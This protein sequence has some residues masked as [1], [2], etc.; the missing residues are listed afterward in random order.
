[1]SHGQPSSRVKWLVAALLSAS[2]AM[3][4]AQNNVTPDGRLFDANPQLGGSRY[5]FARPASPLLGGNFYA[6]GDVRGGFALRSFSPIPSSN[7][8]RAPLGSSALSGFIRDSVSINEARNPGGLTRAPYYDPSANAPSGLYFQGGAYRAPTPGLRA[9]APPPTNAGALGGTLGGFQPPFETALDLRLNPQT[10]Q[11]AAPGFDVRR[12]AE[13]SSSIFGAPRAPAPLYDGYDPQT[14]PAYAAFAPEKPPT[15][16]DLF[17]QD[18]RLDTENARGQWSP[19]DLRVGA[20]AASDER[21]LS[22]VDLMLKRDSDALLT[23]RANIRFGAGPNAP[24]AAGPPAPAP[25]A[26][27]DAL[28]PPS[29][30]ELGLAPGADVFNDLMLAVSLARDPKADWF[31]QLQADSRDPAL[32]LESAQESIA[33]ESSAFVKRVLDTPIRT[34]VGDDANVLND[35]M[36]KAEAF[37]EIGE[38]FDAAGRYER[39]RQI[40]PNNPLP[41]IGKGHAMLAAGDYLS[42]A[43]L[44]TRG[45]EM[46]PQL[47]SFRVDL[48]RLIGGPE[49]VDIRRSDL[50]R[51][52]ER[53]E[54]ARL[55]FLLGYIE[56][57]SGN[58]TSGLAHL[59]K[60]AQSDELGPSLRRYPALLRDRLRQGEPSGEPGA[61]ANPQTQPEPPP[62]DA[63]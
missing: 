55:R 11:T 44:L 15:S 30:K 45:L 51:Q 59:E 1:M 37:M 12:P 19:L 7:A 16:L 53:Y 31:K 8:F 42:A 6:S 22:A 61:E 46:F 21:S 43:V 60:A 62:G 63:P 35:E 36:L 3:T 23:R 13:L 29:L 20:D 54:D 4:I 17:S 5:N 58:T 14:P 56:V 9:F 26:G 27:P 40:A 57:Q 47:A 34:F 48:S 2:P 28:Q 10:P 39:A 49:V 25:L 33:S 50:M 18:L 41:I 52:L 38:Y 24:P 32:A